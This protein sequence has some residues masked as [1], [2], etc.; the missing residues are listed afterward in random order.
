MPRSIIAKLRGLID[1]NITDFYLQL[2]TDQT[3]ALTLTTQSVNVNACDTAINF[4]WNV[5]ETTGIKLEENKDYWYKVN[6]DDIFNKFKNGE[7]ISVVVSNHNDRPVNLDLAV[8]TTCPVILSLE[9][10]RSFPALS[11]YG[12]V[13]TAA[14]FVTYLEKYDIRN[15]LNVSVL[16]MRLPQGKIFLF[17]QKSPLRIFPMA[18]EPA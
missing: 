16:R 4:D 14:D 11:A 6:F 12:V 15:I 18:S 7:D 17:L 9:G 1:P 5:W 13:F 2:T 10:S 3:I 8:S